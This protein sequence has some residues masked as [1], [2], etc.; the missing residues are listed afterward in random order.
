MQP[1]DTYTVLCSGEFTAYICHKIC[2][3]TNLGKY[4]TVRKL[5]YQAPFALLSVESYLQVLNKGLRTTVHRY[6]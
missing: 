1:R 5:E 4:W 2:G 6:N 3:L